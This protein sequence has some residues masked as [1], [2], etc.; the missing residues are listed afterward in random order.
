MQLGQL[1]EILENDSVVMI[2][3]LADENGD[4]IRPEEEPLWRGVT[5][6][7]YEGGR[8]VR[9]AKGTQ[10]VVSFKRDARLKGRLIRQRIKLEP[11]D[12]PTLFG[13]RPI[14]NAF[15]TFERSQPCLSN[16]DGTLFR[17][18]LLN[19]EYDYEVISDRDAAGF[20][21][22]ESPPSDRDSVFLSM[23]VGLRAKLKAIA[24]PVIARLIQTGQT[25]SPRAPRA[26]S[27]SP[28]IG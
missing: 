8:W 23:P 12:S 6:L 27:I 13:I 4:P 10:A 11:I 22:H 17:S 28:R 24:E 21:I 14:L 1:G 2:V 5:M 7:H 20:Q 15:S 3:Q 9:Q 18:D 19:G 16:N 25:L 26:G